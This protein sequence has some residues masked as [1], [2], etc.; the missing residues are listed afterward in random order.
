VVKFGSQGHHNEDEIDVGRQHLRRSAVG[1]GAAEFVAPREDL[2]D[3][4]ALHHHPVP[5]Y[6]NN[7]ERSREPAT[8][9]N[10]TTCFIEPDDVRFPTVHNREATELAIDIGDVD[11]AL[12][13]T[14]GAQHRRGDYQRQLIVRVRQSG[15][16]QRW[17]R[18]HATGDH[19][20]KATAA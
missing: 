10:L 17:S 5:S 14:E 16:G 12:V 2:R 20:V 15:A 19:P 6:R 7:L 3:A 9:L 13:Q 1:L 8:T 11:L 18:S 4:L